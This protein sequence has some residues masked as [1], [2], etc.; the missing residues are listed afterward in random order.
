MRRLR[1]W[2][3][4]LREGG[5]EDRETKQTDVSGCN[6]I[7]IAQVNVG[8]TYKTGETPAHSTS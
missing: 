2:G 8:I 5:G 1:K 7:V 6:V 4:N 3:G